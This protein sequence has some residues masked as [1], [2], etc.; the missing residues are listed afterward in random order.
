M[1]R[2]RFIKSGLRFNF[3]YRVGEVGFVPESQAKELEAAKVVEILTDYNDLPDDLPGKKQLIENGF[4]TLEDLKG[5]NDFTEFPGIG[6]T[7]D[8]RIKSYINK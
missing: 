7:L 6:K 4:K 2:V 1:L 3:A 8:K 5:I